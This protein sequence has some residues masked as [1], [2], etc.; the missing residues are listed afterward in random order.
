MPEQQPYRLKS[1]VKE[2]FDKLQNYDAGRDMYYF[3]R[4]FI[5]ILKELPENKNAAILDFGGGSGL[6]T[7]NLM[8]KGYTNI[9]LLDLSPVQI[10]QAK[11][12]G[13]TK[14]YCG[15]ENYLIKHFPKNTF[16][17]IFMADVIEHLEHPVETLHKINTVLKPGGK[18]ILTFPNPL[19]VP[20]FNI[21]GDIGLKLK[22]KDNKIY[23]RTMMPQLRPSFTLHSF[24]GHMLVSKLPKPIL[25]FFEKVERILPRSFRRWY[26][27]LSIAILEKT[28]A[29]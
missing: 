11:D 17:I 8:K 27:L 19:W 3:Q 5:R 25:S 20:I 21:L 16:D 2:D 23:L 1:V 10:K 14:V 15:D 29:A 13:L 26:G 4:R 28:P 9:S 6:F 24:E 7:S 12:K 18:L 22:G